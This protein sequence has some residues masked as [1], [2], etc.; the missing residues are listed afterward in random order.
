MCLSPTPE[1]RTISSEFSNWKWLSDF[2]LKRLKGENTG[3]DENMGTVLTKLNN[4]VNIGLMSFD[5]EGP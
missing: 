5:E 2:C 3:E 1:A 4:R